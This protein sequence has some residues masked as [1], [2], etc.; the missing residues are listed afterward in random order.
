ALNLRGYYYDVRDYIRTIFGYRPSRVVYNIDKVILW[1]AEVEGRFTLIDGLDV[2]ANYTYQ[3]TRK[4]GDILD[5]SS[6]LSDGLSELPENKV[7]AGIRYS[8]AGLTSELVMRYV[9]RRGVIV[10]NQAREGGSDL[11]Y[12]EDFATF[13]L[14]FSYRLIER[15]NVSA[16]INFG[17]ENLFDASYEETEGFPMPGR[18]LTGGMNIEF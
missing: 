5:R 4:E 11:V 3:D 18:V 2:F 7:N 8:F 13:D 16:K 6:G 14:S 1:G 10:G 9:D 15:D 17:I 12:L